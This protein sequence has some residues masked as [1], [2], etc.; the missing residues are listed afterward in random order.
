MEHTSVKRPSFQFYPGDWYADIKLR[1][2]KLG[3]RGLWIDILC[4]FHQS[5]RGYGYFP[6]MLVQKA[7]DLP[8]IGTDK[9]SPI[10]AMNRLLELNPAMSGVLARMV[11]EKEAVT[12]SYLVELAGAG[13]FSF[14]ETGLAYS[15]RMVKDEELRNIRAKAGALGG[16]IGGKAAKK[17]EDQISLVAPSKKTGTIDY[18]H[19]DDATHVGTDDAYYVLEGE[20][21]LQRLVLTVSQDTI[22]RLRREYPTIDPHSVVRD[23][24]FY[25]NRPEGFAKRPTKGVLKALMSC[26]GRVLRKQGQV[27]APVKTNGKTNAE[28][29][30]EFVNKFNAA[31][32]GLLPTIDLPI[33]VSRETLV[34]SALKARPNMNYWQDVFDAIKT[35]TLPPNCAFDWLIKSEENWVKVKERTY[36]SR[37]PAG[38]GRV[39]D[40]AAIGSGASVSKGL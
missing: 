20:P 5:D 33:S 31:A 3:A 32:K 18:D 21:P 6:S 9:V 30:Q 29:T 24:E 38:A 37:K 23:M 11:G 36:E 34:Q 2:V 28:S 16:A 40:N 14:T 12:R 4:I 8:N 15:K 35:N 27:S 22:D 25:W 13:V 17:K 10:D 1:S 26:A 7:I 19:A 39:N